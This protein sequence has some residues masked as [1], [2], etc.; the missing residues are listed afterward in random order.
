MRISRL[1]A[2]QPNIYCM[3]A[4][5][6]LHLGKLKIKRYIVSGNAERYNGK[7]NSTN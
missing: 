7:Y 1:R 5:K 6:N 2:K 4:F 3:T